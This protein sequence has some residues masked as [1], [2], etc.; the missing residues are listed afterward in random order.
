MSKD[1]RAGV[2]P[3][4]GE[5]ADS[6]A[7]RQVLA[8]CVLLALSYRLNDGVRRRIDA[9]K[10]ARQLVVE[11]GLLNS[12]LVVPST[13]VDLWPASGELAYHLRRCH[14]PGR[15]KGP[16]SHPPPSHARP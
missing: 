8:G 7:A 13:R 14:R 12:L 9:G 15:P 2:P 6:T 5:R 11:A 10:P 1:D 3:V 16:P 4:C